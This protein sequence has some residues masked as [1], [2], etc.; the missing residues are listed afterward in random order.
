MNSDFCKKLMPTYDVIQVCQ[1]QAL[2]HDDSAFGHDNPH[3][4]NNV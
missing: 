4:A 2:K 1:L 3:R